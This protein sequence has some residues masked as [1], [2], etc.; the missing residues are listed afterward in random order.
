MHDRAR[1]R[2]QNTAEPGPSPEIYC[3]EAVKELPVGAQASAALALA[4][5][6]P[7]AAMAMAREAHAAAVAAGIDVD[8]AVALR[9]LGLA[10]RSLHDIA[11]AERYFSDAV[12]AA[13]RAGDADLEAEC[14]VSLA[15]ALVFAGDT[16]AALRTLQ[17]ATP[18]PRTAILVATQEAGILCMVG[19]YAEAI[20]L[21]DPMVRALRRSGDAVLESRV[22][23][24]RA[25]AHVYTGR[26]HQADA[27]LDRVERLVSRLG[28]ELDLA[29]CY[30]NKGFA[31]ARNGD[32]PRALE[33]Y[34]R[35]ARYWVERSLPMGAIPIDRAEALLAAGL[36][37]DAQGEAER[38]TAAARA[39]GDLFDL[40]E[41]LLLL[42]DCAHLAGDPAG[43][44]AAAV[45]A[46]GLFAAQER[47]AWAATARAAAARAALASATASAD[48]A[49]GAAQ[50]AAELDRLGFDSRALAA[51]AVAG[52]L[53]LAVAASLGRAN[54]A[55]AGLAAAEATPAPAE[56]ASSGL[57]AAELMPAP[58]EPQP[59]ELAGA[60]LAKAAAG[61]RRGGAADRVVAW[62]AEGVRRAAAGDRSGAMAALRAAVR[63]VD[64]QQAALSATELRAHISLHADGSAALGLR[65]A[66]DG[67]APRQIF[68]WM[69]RRRANGL[70]AW[71]L[72]PPADAALAGRLA[73]LRALTRD[74]DGAASSGADPRPLSRQIAQVEREVRELAWRSGSG[75]GAGLRGAP[76]AE[77]SAR[78]VSAAL[79]DAVLV[80]LADSGGAL[81]AVVA[82][83]G[84]WHH[85][86][87]GPLS[88]VTVELEHL[89][90]G[91]RRAAYGM[92][93]PMVG[94]P[95]GLAATRLAQLL[96]DPL[97][98]LLGDRPV[99]IVPTG[100]L[101]AVPWAA[102]PGLAGRPVVVAPSATSWLRAAAAPVASG[103]AVAIA[104]PDLPA[105]VAEV[106]GL[107]GVRPG[108]RILTGRRATAAATVRALDGAAIAHIAAHASLNADNG[109]WS[110]L[111]LSDGPL[112]VYELESLPRSPGIVVLSACQSGMSTVRPGDEV[113]GLVAALLAQG[114]RTVIAS[115]LPVGDAATAPVMIEFHRRLMAG[116]GPAL[117]LCGAQAVADD[118]VAAASF[119]C[120]GAG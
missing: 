96:V 13:G 120:F 69:E 112:T 117:A 76:A 99:V 97:R 25:I 85:R 24:N 4:T 18:G 59:S 63:V 87:L 40:A 74:L 94:G 103:P 34:G 50:A 91:L 89:R 43:S 75:A 115:V 107:A 7:Q 14:L 79:G 72:R 108:I 46:A 27:D 68:A 55:S 53:W 21:Y 84:R 100:V 92:R 10:A 1:N 3:R 60:E 20:R 15:S 57:A 109:L 26:F 65:L 67:G 23:S 119:A 81:H 52:K 78:E 102:L 70:R 30:H 48:D 88:A 45:E 101:H 111:H 105:A 95:L 11:A 6:E 83:A 36:V 39:A 58:A 33:M 47:P 93:T 31:A 110:A 28:N 71:P 41:G 42:A 118:V 77:V 61:R 66:I 51:H 12:A 8:A 114:T 98:P 49:A 2:P 116:D 104:G 64:T 35:A 56:P 17:Q 29:D 80:E 38:A 5:A 54:P 113:L 44:K 22:L 9:A 90:F 32:L 19:R 82:G 73:D 86:S 62:D 106:R 37:R 16:D